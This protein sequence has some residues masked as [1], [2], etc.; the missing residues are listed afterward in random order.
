VP[1]RALQ[2][3]IGD[4]PAAS[5]R[6]L[7]RLVV[8][9]LIVLALPVPALAESESSLRSKIERSRDR[10]RALAG[11]AAR[12][13][14][15]ADRAGREVAIV[16]GRLAEVESDLA[17]AEARLA[18][19][20]DRLATGRRRLVRLQ[21]RHAEGR[22]LLAAQLV[23]AYKADPPDIV[24]LVLGADSFADLIE[25][26]AFARRIRD[27]N[28][29]IVGRVRDARVRTRHL[30]SVL[31][32]LAAERREDTQAI[33]ARRAALASMRD[34]LAARQSTLARAEAARTSALAGTRSGRITAQ[35]ALH[36]L[37]E[38]RRR[39]AAIASAGPGGPWAIPWPIVQC[40]SG[41]QNL[42][43]NGAGASG[44]YQMLPE[45]WNGLGGS[46]PH[47]YLAP[48]PEQ[49]RLAAALWAGGA[50]AHNWACAR[51]V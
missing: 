35:R 50:G 1:Q 27:R 23:A 4:R 30:A 42:P 17:S 3:R 40:E 6:R 10:E 7:S 15:L 44:Y 37:I 51:M 34:G 18:S 2:W 48:K 32:R 8:A 38:E 39:A 29:E 33:A 12:L 22:E 19:T 14:Q 36:R 25:G 16:Q 11:A 21:R 9:V 24:S 13:G 20:R 43:P 28:A 5:V 31:G 26:I 47:A 41:G 46:T 49:D 45:T